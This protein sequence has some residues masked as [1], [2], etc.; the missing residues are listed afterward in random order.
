MFSMNISK[1][2]KPV[3]SSMHFEKL[4]YPVMG[5]FE[6]EQD[7]EIMQDSDDNFHDYN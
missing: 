4:R 5:R 1:D 2:N 6:V 3:N 7:I